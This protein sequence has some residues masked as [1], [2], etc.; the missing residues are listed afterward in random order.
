MERKQQGLLRIVF[1]ILPPNLFRTYGYMFQY[2]TQDT[3]IQM[4]VF[5]ILLGKA[6]L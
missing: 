3:V 5:N 1:R 2:L 4:N 6:I